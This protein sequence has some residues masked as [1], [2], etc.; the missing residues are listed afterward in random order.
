M[1]KRDV[2]LLIDDMLQSAQKI[3]RYTSGMDYTSFIADAK[4]VDAVARNFEIIGEASNRIPSDFKDSHPELEWKR[5]KGFRN[6]IVHHYFGIDYEIVWDIIEHYLDG[7]I[8]W[9][10]TLIN[11][12]S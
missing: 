1:S 9:L 8:D 7:L 2:L 5:I 4:T 3:K 11:K 12:Y 10:E 6:R